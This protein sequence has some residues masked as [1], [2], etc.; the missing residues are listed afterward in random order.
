MISLTFWYLIRRERL[1]PEALYDADFR[2]CVDRLSIRALLLA[3]L[4]IEILAVAGLLGLKC[5]DS[6]IGLHA[7]PTTEQ[8]CWGLSR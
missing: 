5:E 1:D 3:W 8:S 6:W 2:N 7:A 4:M